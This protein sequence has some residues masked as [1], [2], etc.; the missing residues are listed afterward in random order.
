MHD[1]LH[2]GQGHVTWTFDNLK[3]ALLLCNAS[4][5][6]VSG[7]GGGGGGRDGDLSQGSDTFLRRCLL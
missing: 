4:L 2:P 6:K 7:W 3:S 5:S 1:N